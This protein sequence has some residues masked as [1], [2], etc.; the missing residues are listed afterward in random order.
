D[1]WEAAERGPYTLIHADACNVLAH[2]ERDAGNKAEAIK[3]ATKAYGLAWCDGPPFAYHW[4][5]EKARGLLRELGAS[6]PEM[7]AFDAGK[8]EAMPEVESDPADEFGAQAG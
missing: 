3:A 1:V 8:F 5:L 2:I 6:E 7:P 4:G